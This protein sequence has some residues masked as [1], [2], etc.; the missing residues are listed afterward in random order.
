[1]GGSAAT[2]R[3]PGL[4]TILL[5]AAIAALGSLATQLIV[6]ALPLLAADLR[7]SAADAQFV[8]GVYLVGLGAGQLVAGPVA[9]RRGRK[10]VLLAGLAL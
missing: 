10:P 1:M 3:P 5:L 4:G 8:I 7:A 6:P 9:D 2:R